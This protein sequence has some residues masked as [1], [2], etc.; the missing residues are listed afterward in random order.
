MPERAVYLTREGKAKLRVELQEL[1]AKRPELVDQIASTR[2]GSTMLEGDPAMEELTRQQAL[3]ESR[4]QELEHMLATAEIIGEGEHHVSAGVSLGYTVTVVDPEG[5]E[6][7]YIIVGSAEADPLAGRISNVSPVGQALLGKH[8]GDS[9]DV[10]VP[11][12]TLRLT[13]KSIE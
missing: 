10:R 1:Q 5:Q 6:S 11:A 12:G 7:K 9:V 13:V 4:I 2:E 8:L 3:T